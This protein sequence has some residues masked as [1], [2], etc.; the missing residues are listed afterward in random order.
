MARK[1]PQ[2]QGRGLTNMWGMTEGGGFFTV[3]GGADLT[4]YPSSVG[5]PY[6]TVELRSLDPD[7]AG[8]ARCWSAPPP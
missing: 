6:P 7:A 5:R 3:A 2:L 4:K 1:L 8:W